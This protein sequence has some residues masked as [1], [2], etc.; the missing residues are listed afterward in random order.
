MRSESIYPKFHFV[1]RC[2]QVSFSRRQLKRIAVPGCKT[3]AEPGAQDQF[4]WAAV[5]CE[6]SG[7]AYKADGSKHCLRRSLTL[8]HTSSTS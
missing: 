4:G 8:N 2:P 6:N 3:R 1:N 7:I 5:L